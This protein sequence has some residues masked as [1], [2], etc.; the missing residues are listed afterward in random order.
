M[1]RRI[2]ATIAAL[3]AVVALVGAGTAPAQAATT[4]YKAAKVIT[5]KGER[6]TVFVKWTGTKKK[7]KP[8]EFGHYGTAPVKVMVATW[9][10]CKGKNLKSVSV[11]YPAGVV[12]GGVIEKNEKTLKACTV[13]ISAY[14][15]DGVRKSATLKLSAGKKQ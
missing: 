5:L 11:E 4:T 8:I 6:T 1:F 13:R 12:R 7:Q 2:T 14:S 15:P 3:F 10:S 9:Y